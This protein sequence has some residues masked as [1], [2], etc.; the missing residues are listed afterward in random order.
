MPGDETAAVGQLAIHLACY[1]PRQRAQ[2]P[3]RRGHAVCPLCQI[4]IVTG[5]HV[6]Y[7]HDAL[8]HTECY[9]RARAGDDIVALLTAHAGTRFCQTC[10]ATRLGLPWDR[11]RKAMWALGATTGFTVGPDSCAGCGTTRVTIATLQAPESPAAAA[12]A[13]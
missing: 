13:S 12:E 2:L 4:P 1:P 7:G 8:V 3:A 10:L 9:D 6:I 5:D 11:V